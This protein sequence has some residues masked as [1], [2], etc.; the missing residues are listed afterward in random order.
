MKAQALPWLLDASNPAVRM[1]TLTDV[2]GRSPN[3]DEVKDARRRVLTYGPV[4]D[5]KNAQAKGGF[6]QP[7]DTSYNPKFTATVW[8]LMLLGEFGTPRTPWI[9]KAVEHFFAQHQMKNG[10]FCCGAIGGKDGLIEEPCLSGNMLRTFLVLGYG[11]DPRLKKGLDW[12][13]EQQFDDG[14]WNCDFPERATTHGSFMSTIEP[15][16]AYSEIPRARWT[17]NMKNS[18]E[19]AAEF[20]LAHRVYKSHSDMRPVKLRD[21]SKFY[22]GNV[23]TRF[24]FP[25]YYYY[26]ALHALRVLTKL[27][28]HDDERMRDAL[29][30]MLSKATKDGRWLLDGDWV[31]ER[32]TRDRRTLVTI[33]RIGEP[34]RWITLNCY[35]VLAAMGDLELPN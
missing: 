35:R 12:L 21:M 23:I 16:W 34:S 5:L 15:L 7:G 28:Y 24:H 2:V 11:E 29:D 17:R 13:P 10:A 9:E 25:M 30:L 8:Q 26:D 6:W 22:A 3:S 19:R 27:G 32:R 14:G 20:L 4:V 18:I 33:D 1:Q 31:R